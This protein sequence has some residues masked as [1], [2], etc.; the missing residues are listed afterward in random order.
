MRYIT[1]FEISENNGRQYG[2]KDRLIY[3]SNKLEC[4]KKKV[5][6]GNIRK[7]SFIISN[8][9]YLISMGG[10]VYC[11]LRLPLSKKVYQNTVSQILSVFIFSRDSLGS[12]MIDRVIAL[13]TGDLDN[14]LWETD[15]R[16]NE[17][18]PPPNL[19]V[20][21]AAFFF[22]EECLAEKVKCIWWMLRLPLSNFIKCKS[23]DTPTFRLICSHHQELMMTAS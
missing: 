14:N 7:C 12:L 13:V 19:H 15:T 20:R 6:N 16:W 5:R 23:M 8:E 9:T 2:V 3:T 4:L 1:Y 10:Q 18:Y 22:R 21:N 17:L 11:S